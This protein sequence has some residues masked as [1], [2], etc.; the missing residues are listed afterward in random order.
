MPLTNIIKTFQTITKLR[1]AQEFGL[2][3]RSGEITR[4]RTG[5]NTDQSA[6][7]HSR[8]FTWHKIQIVF[9]RGV[10]VLIVLS[11]NVVFRTW[12]SV[13]KHCL[14]VNTRTQIH[15]ENTPIQMYRKFHLQKTEIF[16]IKNSDIFSYFC[17][18]HRL[19]VLVRTASARRGGSNEYP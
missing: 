1:C 5:Q 16:Q 13:D 3:I 4:T 17:S 7:P 15:Y 10:P 19:W 6:H 2:K 9:R 12:C 8:L 14:P 18:K 11:Q